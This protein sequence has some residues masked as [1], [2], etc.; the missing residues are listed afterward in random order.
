MRPFIRKQF[1]KI[2]SDRS[3]ITSDGR[4]LSSDGP[5]YVANLLGNLALASYP[6]RSIHVLLNDEVSKKFSSQR[7]SN[8]CQTGS[9]RYINNR[10]GIK[11]R[12]PIVDRRKQVNER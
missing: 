11:W 6:L 4:H 10:T 9:R 5:S 7:R 3:N 1:C 2:A 8:A 12:S